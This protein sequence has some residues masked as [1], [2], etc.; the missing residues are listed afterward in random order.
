MSGGRLSE[1]VKLIPLLS[2]EHCHIASNATHL[3]LPL[4]TPESLF[5]LVWLLHAQSAASEEEQ[6]AIV[7]SLLEL[8][9]TLLVNIS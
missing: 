3:T 6:G 2:E 7:D 1:V 9:G 4:A 5:T 8:M